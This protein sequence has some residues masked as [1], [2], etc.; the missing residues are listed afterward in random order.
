[1]QDEVKMV[2]LGTNIKK[3]AIPDAAERIADE[4]LKVI[5]KT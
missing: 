4:I 3:M 2:A 5:K 1:M